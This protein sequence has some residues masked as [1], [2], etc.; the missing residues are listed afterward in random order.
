MPKGGLEPPCPFEYPPTR[1]CPFDGHGLKPTHYI[2]PFSIGVVLFY[3]GGCFRLKAY[4]KRIG[5]GVN[6]RFPMRWLKTV[7][8][9]EL[10]NIVPKVVSMKA[11]LDELG[12][13]AHGSNYA[14]AWKRIRALNL[15]TTHWT[16]QGYLKG[17]H[18]NWNRKTPL[19]DLLVESSTYGKGHLK[20]RL[21][22]EGILPNKCSNPNCQ[23]TSEWLGKPLILVLDHIN[24]IGND[25]RLE[26][27][28][29]LC[30]NCN[31]QTDTFCG[32]NITYQKNEGFNCPGCGAPVAA[33]GRQCVKCAA[34][35]R[36]LSKGLHLRSE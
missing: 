2:Y 31:S 20:R 18:H 3:G 32:K 29:L 1:E 24:G 34:R 7:T 26:N 35:S 10:R 25:D 4:S 22:S 28:R 27:L 21:L 5:R 33:K 19:S 36:V 12:S 9:D 6:M 14:T 30:P 11:L 23:I 8:D 16:G 15:D 13:N 17:G